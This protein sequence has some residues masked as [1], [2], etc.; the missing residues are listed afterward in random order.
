MPREFSRHQRLGPQILRTLNEL[1]ARESRD[2]RLRGVSLTAVDLSRDISVAR[3]YFSLL[4][5]DADPGAAADGLASAAGFLRTRLGESLTVRRVPELRFAHDVSIAHGAE[6][7]QLI[8]RAR[9]QDP[10]DGQE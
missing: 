7:S 3:V 5:P 1:V 6:I 2:P 4:D 9:S 8:D 10:S